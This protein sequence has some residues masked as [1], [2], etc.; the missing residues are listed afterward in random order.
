MNIT[1]VLIIINTEMHIITVAEDGRLGDRIGKK[2]TNLSG[3]IPLIAMMLNYES[4]LSVYNE[5]LEKNPI[6]DVHPI[7]SI[8]I[9]N[10][11]VATYKP[12]VGFVY[13]GAIS[14][15]TAFAKQVAE[16]ISVASYDHLQSPRA[17]SS[18]PCMVTRHKADGSEQTSFMEGKCFYEVP[19]DELERN[20]LPARLVTVSNTAYK[21]PLNS[22]R[23]VF[24]WIFLPA[25]YAFEYDT[26][27]QSRSVFNMMASSIYFDNS[28][29]FIGEKE[30]YRT[31]LPSDFRYKESDILSLNCVKSEGIMVLSSGR[32]AEFIGHRRSFINMLVTANDYESLPVLPKKMHEDIKSFKPNCLIC[33][34][35]LLNAVIIT[36]LNIG[37]MQDVSDIIPRSDKDTVALCYWCW[38]SLDPQDSSSLKSY[39]APKFFDYASACSINPEYISLPLIGTAVPLKKNSGG[40][41]VNVARSDTS[42]GI[43]GGNAAS[44]VLAGKS[45]GRC[46]QVTDFTIVQ[47]LFPVFSDLNIAWRD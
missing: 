25:K 33:C 38:G 35:P 30:L 34:A 7:I 21:Y 18:T 10:D 39:K 19:F 2:G 6:E 4:G 5:R 42:S 23:A 24:T 37:L 17:V 1:H 3:A 22:A 40:F 41:L 44:V 47:S 26:E 11:N 46:P 20:G 14:D 12:S 29:Y 28:G 15:I 45:L 36:G 43:A 32:S 13:C 9:G 16:M 27:A 8:P 31:L